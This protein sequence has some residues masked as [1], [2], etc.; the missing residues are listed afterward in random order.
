MRLRFFMAVKMRKHGKSIG[1]KTRDAPAD[2]QGKAAIVAQTCS[3]RIRTRQTSP[4]LACLFKH[5]GTI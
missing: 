3:K 1:R 2:L 5:H 4:V